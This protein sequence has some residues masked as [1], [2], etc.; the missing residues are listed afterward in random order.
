[1]IVGAGPDMLLRGAKAATSTVPIVMTGSSDPVTDR[2][3]ASLAR[4]GG[5]MTGISLMVAELGSKRVG[6]LKGVVPYVACL[7]RVWSPA[8]QREL[9]V[10]RAAADKLGLTL[11]LMEVR[12]TDDLARAF[13][14]LERE[15]PD[16]LTMST[17]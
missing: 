13:A 16:A 2:F 8:A 7:A 5:N 17:G 14:V 1:I 10:T 4:P 12:N 9:G 6:L 15:R 3:I 11:K